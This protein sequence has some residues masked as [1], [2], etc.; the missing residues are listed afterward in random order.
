[1]VDFD[2]HQTI[3][4]RSYKDLVDSLNSG[5]QNVI[6]NVNEYLKSK[7]IPS[8]KDMDSLQWKELYGSIEDKS[9]VEKINAKNRHQDI[10]RERQKQE[11]NLLSN[12]IARCIA[13]DTCKYCSLVSAAIIYII[14]TIVLFVYGLMGGQKSW[15]FLAPAIV[16]T[17]APVLIGCCGF[18]LPLMIYICAGK[19]PN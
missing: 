15:E 5:D 1:M 19:G 14:V 9:F 2:I 4:N 6:T 3:T 8:P 10:Q 11:D 16:L 18:V 13:S 7:N 12:R 17:A